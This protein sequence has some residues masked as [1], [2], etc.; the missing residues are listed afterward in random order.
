MVG[1]PQEHEAEK[2][3]K[4]VRKITQFTVIFHFFLFSSPSL[5]FLGLKMS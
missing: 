4:E 3:R 2:R 5:R 1:V